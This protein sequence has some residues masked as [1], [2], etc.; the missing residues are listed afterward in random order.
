MEMYAVK[1]IDPFGKR[2][3]RGKKEGEEREAG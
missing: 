1:V 2:G 3:G